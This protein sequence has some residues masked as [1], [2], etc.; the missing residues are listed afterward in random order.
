METNVTQQR[1]VQ[2]VVST[3]RAVHD[4]SVAG[5]LG[6]IYS[7]TFLMTLQIVPKIQ[8]LAEHMRHFIN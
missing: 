1:E 4:E 5:A 8:G 3:A 2:G 7:T 6:I